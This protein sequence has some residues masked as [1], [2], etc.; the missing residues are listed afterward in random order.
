MFTAIGIIEVIFIVSLVSKENAERDRVRTEE[1]NLQLKA[2]VQ[3]VETLAE[4]ASAANR[5][6]S[7]FL[8][9]MSHEIRTP[10]NAILGYA[11]FLSQE[12]LTSQQ[13]RC[14]DII[15]DNSSQLLALIND[16][17]DLSKIEAEELRVE[18]VAC[19]L[20]Q[21]LH[22]IESLMSK[23]AQ[24]KSLDFR[25]V[26][27][28]DLPIQVRSDPLRIHQCLNNL[29]GNGIKFTEHGHVYLNVQLLHEKD[30]SLIQFAVEDTGIGIAPDKQTRVFDSFSQADNSTCRKY[31]GTGL[32][33]SIT[34]QLAELLG[35]TVTLTSQAGEGSTF[36]LT[37]PVEIVE[38]VQTFFDIHDV[39]LP[40]K[41]QPHS[42]QRFVAGYTILVAD[43]V[44]I[45]RMLMQQGIAVSFKVEGS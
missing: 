40:D 23:N 18:Y 19:S 20:V 39:D 27:H 35:G 33:L 16:I 42:A 4:Q 13:N 9:N 24:E 41:P 31:G 12:K 7:E 44:R 22:S 14:A 21:L 38:P 25:V 36:S 26:C 6:K 45:N 3:E 32:G 2:Y 28:G 34:R 11:D 15:L 37:V 29:V 10:M 43:D 30:K 5:A 8:A 1:T 17:M